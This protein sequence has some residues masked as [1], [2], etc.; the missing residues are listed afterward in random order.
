VERSEEGE[1]QMMLPGRVIH[2]KDVDHLELTG[3]LI[4]DS[5]DGSGVGDCKSYR[6]VWADSADSQFNEILID[7]DMLTTHI[8]THT[9]RLFD[10]VNVK[11][12]RVDSLSDLVGEI[13]FE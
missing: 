2:F 7:S 1:M 6:P 13:A 9:R 8:P 12:D 3:I 5:R 10:I 11:L 4:E